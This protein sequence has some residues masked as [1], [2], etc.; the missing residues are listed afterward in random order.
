M[1]SRTDIS[2]YADIL[3]LPHQVSASRSH[4]TMQDRAAQFSPFA[5]LTGYDAVIQETA[6]LTETPGEL[7]ESRKAILDGQLQLLLE[8]LDEQPKITVTYFQPDA[9]KQGGAYVRHTGRVKKIDAYHRMLLMADG[10]E[11]LFER[12]SCL[13]GEVFR[14]PDMYDE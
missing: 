5:A 14:D 4:M 7:D 13:E 9:R 11:I 12:L 3:N 1:D 8:L 2:K 10:T 6:R